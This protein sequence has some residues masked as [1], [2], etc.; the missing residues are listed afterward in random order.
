M[1]GGTADATVIILHVTVSAS[2]SLRSYS[3]T[4]LH[5]TIA[6]GVC[7]RAVSP[8]SA[9]RRLNFTPTVPYPHSHDWQA[10]CGVC[11]WLPRLTASPLLPPPDQAHTLGRVSCAPSQ[12]C[13]VM[14]KPR[15]QWGSAAW[16]KTKQHKA[17]TEVLLSSLDPL[18]PAPLF[19]P[20]E[21][22]HRTKPSCYLSCAN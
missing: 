2:L 20:M 6:F 8:A 16:R 4:K 12:G 18:V 19:L 14:G 3:S 17:L 10:S 15:L 22:L 1:Y 9:V 21:L 7:C 13:Q 11:I 5:L